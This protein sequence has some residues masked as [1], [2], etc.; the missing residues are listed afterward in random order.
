[1]KSLK[2]LIVWIAVAALGLGMWLYV[3]HP[4]FSSE[5]T[6]YLG[7]CPTPL[8][9]GVCPKGEE[10]GQQW[11]Y[12]ASEPTQSVVYW[13]KGGAPYRITEC[14]VRDAMNWTCHAFQEDEESMFDG[15]L[16]KH[17]LPGVTYYQVS[18]ARWYWLWLNTTGA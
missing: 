11:I 17:F 18:K 7:W 5:V 16:K 2:D 4:P 1:M 12:K 8:E 14:A 13:S 6:V 9:A 10:S 15:R 3:E